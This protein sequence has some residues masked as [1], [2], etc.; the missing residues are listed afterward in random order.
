MHQQPVVQ[1]VVH[2]LLGVE[3]PA[4]V[5]PF[6]DPIDDGMRLR[7]VDGKWKVVDMFGDPK[8]KAYLPNVMA[9]MTK[10]AN[11]T[12]AVIVLREN[13]DDS[14]I[15]AAAKGPVSILLP[16]HG[17]SAI[18]GAGQPFDDPAARSALYNT[19][20]GQ[21]GETELIEIDA[22]INDE[23]FAE[24]AANRLLTLLGKYGFVQAR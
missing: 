14:A 13:G 11:E 12:A 20:R 17:V 16:L 19:I 10:A 3:L 8:A 7:K 5:A 23:Q 9:A 18:D 2:A 4:L 22:H 15:P 21:H 24:A 6:L 1:P